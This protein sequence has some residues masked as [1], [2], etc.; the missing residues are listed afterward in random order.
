MR[1]CVAAFAIGCAV[2]VFGACTET[3]GVPTRAAAP[4]RL[5]ASSTTNLIAASHPNSEKYR[6]SGFH[7]ATGRSGTAVV[8][9]RALIDKSG[10]T[11]VE[12]TT[13]AFDGEAPLAPH[14]LVS[15]Q[16][17]AFGPSGRLAFTDNHN[18]LSGEGTASFAYTTLP[19]GTPLQVQ[20]LAHD[21]D[22]A[23]TDVV[24]VADTVHLRPDLVASHLEAPASAPIGAPVNLLAFILER[25]GEVGAR[26][27]CV[28]YAD[29]GSTPVDRADGIWVDAGGTVTC[30]MTHT[31][32]EAGTHSLEVRVESVRPAD[33]DDT[34]NSV[35]TS[36]SVVA[37]SDFQAYSFQAWS[38][39]D[40]AWWH[41]VSTLTTSD[42]TVE[43]WDQ[44]YTRQGPEQYAIFDGIIPRM[45]TFPITFRGEMTT[46]GSTV[47]SV[48]L[49]HSTG[50]WIDWQQAYCASSFSIDGGGDTYVCVYTGGY[51]A[52]YTFLQYDWWGADV[53]YHSEGYV[54]SWDA[55]GQLHQR[56]VSNDW[57]QVGPMVTFGP[58]FSSRLSVQGA[59][60][61]APLTAQATVPLEPIDLR[62]DHVDPTCSTTPPTPGCFELH[63][64]TFGVSGF[65][66]YG[67]WRPATP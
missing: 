15:A 34:N 29:G 33:F 63:D 51:L 23:R 10:T 61:A 3:T 41:A 62:F 32:T 4:H 44:T 17:K 2:V 14:T 18:G 22:A 12:V 5:L 6:D 57:S 24:T 25:N 50:D 55:S 26:A 43:T 9:T 47:N 48:D 20:T 28:L 11:D 46:N 37:P 53:R 66:N 8:S 59:D 27:D 38:V 21:S 7:P 67:D 35:T 54:T 36:I 52:G 64:H 31:F 58:D 39:V 13:G 40:S 1:H 42:G 30:A 56:W 19:H 65:V 60:D 16:V 49:T 45:L